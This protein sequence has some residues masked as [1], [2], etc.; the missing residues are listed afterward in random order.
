[1]QSSEVMQGASLNWR[2]ASNCQTGECVEIAAQEGVVVMRSSARP[3]AGYIYFEP[4]EFGSF[5]E[6]VKVPGTCQYP[7]E[8]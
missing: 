8:N 5:L 4:N 2:R 7:G 6:A 3:D 1:M